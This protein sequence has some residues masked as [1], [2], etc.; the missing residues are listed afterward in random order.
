MDNR[1]VITKK[2]NTIISAFFEGK[3][4]VS[5]SLNASEEESILGNI[6]LGKVKHLLEVAHYIKMSNKLH[7]SIFLKFNSNLHS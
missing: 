2:E 1:L 4:M 6:Y 5:V 7:R 3:D